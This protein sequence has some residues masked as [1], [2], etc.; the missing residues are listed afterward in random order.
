MASHISDD[1]HSGA[2]VDDA[3]DEY[4]DDESI[5]STRR[6]VDTGDAIDKIIHKH[7]ATHTT[8][9]SS[10]SSIDP[11]SSQSAAAD[12]RTVE[13]QKQS[14][15]SSHDQSGSSKDNTS[16]PTI[17]VTIQNNSNNTAASSNSDTPSSSTPSTTVSGRPRPASLLGRDRDRR[18]FAGL[19]GVLNQAKTRAV[20][21]RTSERVLKQIAVNQRVAEKVEG[22][23]ERLKR[24]KDE[25][26]QVE[27]KKHQE[28]IERKTRV[29]QVEIMVS[30]NKQRVGHHFGSEFISDVYSASIYL[31]VC[32]IPFVS[33]CLL[34]V[35]SLPNS[36]LAP[37]ELPFHSPQSSHCMVTRQTFRSDKSIAGITEG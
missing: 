8:S 30:T 34:P 27:E 12:M 11:E 3:Y 36:S 17:T 18:M 14:D 25:R 6:A 35:S 26:R 22:L 7:N 2:G 33:F 9:I 29:K 4:V 32:S 13:E 5:E 20:S 15:S 16:L 23:S 28:R 19:L 37:F 10:S 21:E 31:S 1:T 24:E